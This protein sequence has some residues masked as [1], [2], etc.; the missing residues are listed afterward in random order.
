V[1]GVVAMVLGSVML[2]K[3]DAPFLRVSWTV[4]VPV[5]ATAGI[6]SLLI[7]GMGV[8]AMR[9]RPTTGSEG[10]IGLIGVAKTA[11][12]PHGQI[13]VRGEIWEAS[14]AVPLQPGA[15]VEVTRIEGLK[16]HVKPVEGEGPRP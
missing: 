9:K 10:M 4:I 14:S 16:L 12:A 13:Q 3:A 8:R 11:L 2:M 15:S 1:F 5:V 6:V 7:V